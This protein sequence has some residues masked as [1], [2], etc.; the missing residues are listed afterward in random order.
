MIVQVAT[1]PVRPEKK[2]EF[3]A[4][5]EPIIAAGRQEPGLNIYLPT[6]KSE[7]EN[8]GVWIE[9]Y[10]SQAVFDAH[11]QTEMTQRLVAHLADYLAAP[12]EI[13]VYDV[14]SVNVQT[15]DSF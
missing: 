3:I 13:R 1:F 14:N 11:M 5:I 10:E 2:A 4:F 6:W 9:E 15:F 8:V 12:P 7:D